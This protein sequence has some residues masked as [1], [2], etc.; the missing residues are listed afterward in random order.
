MCP[1][2]RLGYSA[3]AAAGDDGRNDS[4]KQNTHT[5]THPFNGPLSGSTR[6]SGYQRGS[7]KPIWILLKQ[8]TVSGSGISW[9]ICKSALRFR[10]ITMPAPRHSVFTD[11]M[12]FMPLSQQ[13]QSTEGID[14]IDNITQHNIIRLPY[15]VNV[16][17]TVGCPSVC[18]VD[19]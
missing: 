4:I 8:E 6:V 2:S 1:A 3:A 12:P 18:P 10:Q 9:A 5:H 11:R 19:R 15:A 13:R 16:H 14:N 17:L 7:L